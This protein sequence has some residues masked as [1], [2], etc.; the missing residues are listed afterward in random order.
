M[1]RTEPDRIVEWDGFEILLSDYKEELEEEICEVE[2]PNCAEEIRLYPT[3]MHECIMCGHHWENGL[4]R[5]IVY[6]V[7]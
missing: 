5:H 3:M 1:S 6:P 4:W 2:C 7:D